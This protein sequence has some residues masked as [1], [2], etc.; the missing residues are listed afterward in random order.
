[1]PAVLYGPGLKNSLSLE[2][3]SKDFEKIFNEAWESALISLEID[4]KK[5]LV[6]IH[7]IKK[8]QLSGDIIHIDFYQPKAGKEIEAKAPL[9]FE[10]IALAVKDLGGTLVKNIQE[11]HIR[12]L[13]ENLP[14]QI[15][16]DI[17]GLKTF[18]DNILVKD[19]VLPQGIMV[20]KEPNDIVAK[21][22]PAAKIKEELAK[23]IEEKVAP[24]EVKEE[25]VK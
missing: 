22:V 18:E 15:S 19:L 14:H 9:V 24:E 2:I 3:N 12:A 23:P 16:V 8:D 21:V 4:G 1:M 17:S 13:P 7:E 5:Y 25:L 6:L 20:L 10:G 11:I